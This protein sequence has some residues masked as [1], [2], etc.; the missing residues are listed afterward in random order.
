MGGDPYDGTLDVWEDVEAQQDWDALVLGNGMSI[1]LWRDFDYRSL[2]RRARAGRLLSPADRRLFAALRLQN[3]EQ[4]LRRLSDA[5]VVGEALG[6]KRPVE[7]ARHA[8]IQKALAQAVRDV[9]VEGK[10]VPVE[11]FEDINEE[12]RLYRYVFTTSYD[13]LVYWTSAK[14][15]G[16]PFEDYCD[17]FW[18][19]RKNAFDESSIKLSPESRR[20]RLYYLHGALHLVVLG[21]GTTCKRKANGLTLLDQF[22][23]PFYG[24]HTARPL[25]VTEAAAEDKLRSI[26]NNDYL[27]YC[28][29]QLDEVDRPVVVFGHSLSEQDSHLIDVLNGH[30][31][32]P[33]A[34]SLLDADRDENRSNQHRIASLL[35]GRPL[36]FFDAATHPLG[37]EELAV[38]VL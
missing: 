20:T 26:N 36:Y 4:V 31:D 22:G 14:G 15:P 8:S 16:R 23:E 33:V 24:D 18:A 28:W 27:S 37:S 34:V 13:L 9:H 30:P 17:F 35:R 38:E 5:I 19:G 2:Y 12:L 3:F 29:E 25:I 21:D 10:D 11:C 6:K 32:R 1:N 7:R